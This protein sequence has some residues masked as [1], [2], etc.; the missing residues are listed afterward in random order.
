MNMV[1]DKIHLYIK[2]GDSE[3]EMDADNATES[4]DPV[5]RMLALLKGVPI[6]AVVSPSGELKSMNGYD[7]I[8]EKVLASFNAG[9]P[10][11]KAVASKQ[12]DERIKEGLIKSN[13]EEFLRIFP[14]SAVHVGDRWK[15]SS[16]QNDQITLSSTGSYQLKKIED[17]T[18]VIRVEGKVS[19]VNTASQM[20]GYTVN[21]NLDG[22][23]EGE[24][25]MEVATGMMLR[26]NVD[27]KVEGTLAVF[28]RDIPVTINISMK[29]EGRAL[30]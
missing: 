27:S 18:A 4:D 19:A 20:N 30:K 2:N 15:L 12:W 24:F 28:G 25:D 21:A 5:E 22:D 26:A 29:T 7:A 13:M 14:D 11:L 16:T 3:K 6:Q 1:Y 10:N 23:Q 9:N 17:G 8:K